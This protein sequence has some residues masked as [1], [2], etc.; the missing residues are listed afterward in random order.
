MPSSPEDHALSDTKRDH[1]WEKCVDGDEKSD[2]AESATA[3]L[4][5]RTDDQT[6]PTSEV[7][8]IVAA[9]T[10]SKIR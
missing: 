10:K 6:L 8:D 4:C 3:S 9:I 5:D 2:R 1:C 7:S